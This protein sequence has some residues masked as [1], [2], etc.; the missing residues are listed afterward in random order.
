MSVSEQCRQ[1]AFVES[2]STECS[3]IYEF[4]CEGSPEDVCRHYTLRDVSSAIGWQLEAPSIL[5]VTRGVCF[6]FISDSHRR[7]HAVTGELT[8]QVD[9]LR[10]TMGGYFAHHRMT[11]NETLRPMLDA[12]GQ[13]LPEDGDHRHY[14]GRNLELNN[15][16]RSIHALVRIFCLDDTYTCSPGLTLCLTPDQRDSRELRILE[17]FSRRIQNQESVAPAL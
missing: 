5:R 12:A 10:G 4:S 17:T 13:R 3:W 8:C 15:S 2:G 11:F 7:Q 14:A 9:G 16:R 6:F 1:I